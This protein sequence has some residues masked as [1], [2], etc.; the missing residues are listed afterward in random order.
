MLHALYTELLH[1]NYYKW[2]H[3]SAQ[4]SILLFKY[5]P[6]IKHNI[7]SRN[8][9]INNAYLAQGTFLLKYGPHFREKKHNHDLIFTYFTSFL[10][11]QKY[12]LH[13]FILIYNFD[14]RKVLK[15]K[16]SK[17]TAPILIII[18]ILSQNLRTLNSIRN[19]K[20]SL[21]YIHWFLTTLMY[22][23]TIIF[24]YIYSYK[25]SKLRLSIS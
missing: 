1:E 8:A 15:H 24:W 16:L 5:S 12:R 11:N 10:M 7:A 20:A 9:L 2:T 22:S 13:V 23:Q 25:H 17:V 3:I 19:A 6:R 18:S 21:V 4:D 14:W